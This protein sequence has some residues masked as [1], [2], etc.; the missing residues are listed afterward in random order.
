MDHDRNLSVAL[1][2]SFIFYHVL[3]NINIIYNE[4]T[5]IQ[6]E[7]EYGKLIGFNSLES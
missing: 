4:G 5:L 2:H 6:T 3:L 1:V 7:N